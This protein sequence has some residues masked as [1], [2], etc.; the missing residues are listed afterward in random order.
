MAQIGAPE[1][2]VQAPVPLEHP[3]IPD[4]VPPSWEPALV[5]EPDRE[6]VPA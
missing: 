1:K 6:L 4:T 5:P 3:N 2:I